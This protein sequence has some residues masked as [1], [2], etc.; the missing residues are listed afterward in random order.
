VIITKPCPAGLGW[1]VPMTVEEFC[2]SI[3]WARG[4][5]LPIGGARWLSRFA[6][7][8]GRPA[9]YRAGRVLLAGGHG[10]GDW[11]DI[12]AG[13]CPSPPG[14]LPIWPGEDVAWAAAWDARHAG[15]L[16]RALTIWFGA[17]AGG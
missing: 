2:G 5:G 7:V 15:G 4:R 8:G 11:V 17:P 6:N 3:R 16:R 9:R 1:E 10:W 13:R 14:V 12:L